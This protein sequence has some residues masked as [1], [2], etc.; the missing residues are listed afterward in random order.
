GTGTLAIVS[1]N[2]FAGVHVLSKRAAIEVAKQ[3][4]TPESDVSGA[5]PWKQPV[6]IREVATGSWHNIVTAEDLPLAERKLNTWLVKPTD[7]LFA[8]MNRKV[9]IPI[10]R[11]LIKFPIT[12]N[13][14]TFFVLGVS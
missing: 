3:S 14:V 2:A 11:Q 13:M 9:S 7:G 4:A 12:P 10:S 6:E 5:R 8:Q 1:N